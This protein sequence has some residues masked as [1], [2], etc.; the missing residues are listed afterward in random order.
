M[1]GSLGAR[2][3]A[4]RLDLRHERVARGYQSFGLLGQ[5]PERGVVEQLVA[6]LDLLG[7]AAPSAAQPFQ[8]R[9]HPVD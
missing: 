6:A 8:C 7:E 9:D 4:Q 3:S 1:T 5:A 2:L